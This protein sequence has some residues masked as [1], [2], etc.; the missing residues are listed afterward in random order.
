MLQLLKLQFFV[1]ENFAM[2][3]TF[4]AA[5]VLVLQFLGFATH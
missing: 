2:A 1:V 3:V 4:E 5:I